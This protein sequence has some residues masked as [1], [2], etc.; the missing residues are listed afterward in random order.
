MTDRERKKLRSHRR[1]VEVAAEDI[2]TYGL[3]A[4]G[5]KSIMQRAGLTHGGFYNHFPDKT[6]MIEEA[7]RLACEYRDAWLADLP[8]ATSPVDRVRLLADRYLSR[9]HRDQPG[10][11]CPFPSLAAEIARESKP[12]RTVF[13][14]EMTE[15]LRRLSE[16]TS[17]SDTTSDQDDDDT[18][19]ALM[20]LC[21]GAVTLS[22]AVVDNELA[23]R[24]LAAASR[25]AAILQDANTGG[26]LTTD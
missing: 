4:T 19:L 22:R 24:I 13:E 5:V 6:A 11:G 18:T 1:I 25:T 26:T 2:R 15:T 14:S 17:A 12:I 10:S 9:E 8:E 7:F 16:K 20:A 23:D 21:V 3:G